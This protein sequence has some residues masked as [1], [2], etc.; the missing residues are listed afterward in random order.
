MLTDRP[1]RADIHFVD[2][3]AVRFHI[4]TPESKTVI[5]LSMAI[6]CWPDLVQYGA[7]QHLEQD[8]AD[9]ILP[10]AQTEQGFNV[11]LSIDLERLPGSP[12]EC[13]CRGVYLRGCGEVFAA[14]TFP[15]APKVPSDCLERPQDHRPRRLQALTLQKNALR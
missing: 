12:G 9:Y 3:D 6:Q 4:S 2:Y 7:R 15:R 11:S 10:E 14:G 8:Y 1:S 5:L 13:E